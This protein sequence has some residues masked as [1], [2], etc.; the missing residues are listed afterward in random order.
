V[1]RVGVIAALVAVVLAAAAA[2]HASTV[3]VVQGRGWGHGIGMSQWGAYGF[4]RHGWSYPR[5]LR[6]YYPGTRLVTVAPTTIRVLL[7][8]GRPRLDIGCAGRIV[9]SDRSG[10]TWGLPASTYRI[11]SRLRLPLAHKRITLTRPRHGRR[12]RVVTVSIPLRPPL[13]FD[14]PTMPLV[15]DGRAYHGRLVLHRPSRRLYVVNSLDLEDYLRGVVPGEM[16]DRWPLAALAAQAVAART[17][18][19]AAQKP[20]GKWDVYADTRSQVYGGIAYESPRTD[21]AIA[22]THGRALY[23]NGAPASTFFFSTS[24]GRTAAVED[25]W[26]RLGR[27]PYLRSVADPYELPSPH[28]RWG[29]LGITA[30]KL[31]SALH[32]THAGAITFARGPS[33]R[34]TV[35]QVGG[36]TIP[37][38]RFRSALHLASTWF[39]IGR[40]TLT[41]A[42]GSLTADKPT[43]RGTVA[44]IA[45]AALQARASD[46]RWRTLRTVRQGAFALR[47][48]AGRATSY[49]LTASGIATAPVA[50]PG[51]ARENRHTS[52]STRKR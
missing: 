48:R 6:H 38:W 21:R 20:A 40:L 7:A 1:T 24:G 2:A 43:L 16:P 42:R 33:G 9:V 35:V 8:Q 15:L 41:A 31:R 44:G 45:R 11:G 47:V 23:W 28:L 49:R 17:Y 12:F 39:A 3:Y 5:I 32:L 14:C 36:K 34:V 26:P 18:A 10:R 25:V 19:L 4:A 22:R 52:E 13:V 30:R 27:V 46:G 29:P 37:G 50:A 51:S